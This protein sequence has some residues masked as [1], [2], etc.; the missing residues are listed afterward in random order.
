MAVRKSAQVRATLPTRQSRQKLPG[1][2]LLRRVQHGQ[3]AQAETVVNADGSHSVA[4]AGQAVEQLADDLLLGRIVALAE[5][6]FQLLQVTPPVL[7]PRAHA[8]EQDDVGF[9]ERAP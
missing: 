5:A 9:V 6:I 3:E 4:G 8:K 7:R 2:G 1:R